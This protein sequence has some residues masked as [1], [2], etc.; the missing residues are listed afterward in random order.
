ME[1]LLPNVRSAEMCSIIAKNVIALINAL[2]VRMTFLSCK[3]MESVD[4]T[5]E[6]RQ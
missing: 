4:A 5:E 2:L 1:Q 6:T 3:M